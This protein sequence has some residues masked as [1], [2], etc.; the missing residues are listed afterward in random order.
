MSGQTAVLAIVS[1]VWHPASGSEQCL[2]LLSGQREPLAMPLANCA[3]QFWT[4]G[5]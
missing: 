5:W 1:V 3:L 2:M 4:G